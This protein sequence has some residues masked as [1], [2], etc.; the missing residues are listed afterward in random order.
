[1]FLA[2]ISTVTSHALDLSHSNPPEVLLSY[3]AKHSGVDIWATSG[4]RM[5]RLN[6]AGLLPC[7]AL[8]PLTFSVRSDLMGT[9]WRRGIGN[10]LALI[11]GTRS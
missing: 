1:M 6:M 5:G 7:M 9:S 8:R 10:W 3:R 4:S 11:C 2:V